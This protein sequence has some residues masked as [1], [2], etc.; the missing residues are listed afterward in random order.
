M[1]K[2][3]QGQMKSMHKDGQVNVQ[4]QTRSDE[5]DVEANEDFGLSF[6]LD[7]RL[8]YV[9]LCTTTFAGLW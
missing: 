2:D 1:C 9:V 8:L 7:F 4:G 3:K 6:A 5:V